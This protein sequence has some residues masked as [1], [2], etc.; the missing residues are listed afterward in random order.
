MSTVFFL[1]LN[2]IRK[3]ACSGNMRSEQ[4]TRE[5]LLHLTHSDIDMSIFRR[6]VLSVSAKV[7]NIGN[8][9]KISKFGIMRNS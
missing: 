9:L 7:N 2:Y 5:Q 3:T 8:N 6:I 4:L 1:I